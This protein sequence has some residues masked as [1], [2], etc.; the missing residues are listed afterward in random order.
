[1]R[2]RKD[3]LSVATNLKVRLINRGRRIEEFIAHIAK[4]GA[5]MV[6]KI[7]PDRLETMRVEL[8]SAMLNQSRDVQ[9]YATLRWI[10]GVT[11]EIEPDNLELNK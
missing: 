5:G 1:M 2:E 3:V 8:D 4:S 11:E 9:Q 7:H 6:K 10:L